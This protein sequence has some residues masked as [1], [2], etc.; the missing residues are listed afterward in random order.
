MKTT[1]ISQVGQ[2][3]ASQIGADAQTQQTGLGKKGR[4]DTVDQFGTA[5]DGGFTQQYPCNPKPV[6][7]KPTP[8]RPKTVT[9]PFAGSASSGTPD[10]FRLM[11]PPGSKVHANIAGTSQNGGGTWGLVISDG[12]SQ[13]VF[14]N[15]QSNCSFTVPDGLWTVFFTS[16]TDDIGH[17]HGEISWDPP[18][19]DKVRGMNVTMRSGEVAGDKE[20]PQ[21]METWKGRLSGRMAAVWGV[22][23][24]RDDYLG[25]QAYLTHEWPNEALDT[26]TAKK[27]VAWL[28]GGAENIPHAD[29]P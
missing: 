24:R 1:K 23:D 22:K 6:S 18:P 21:D 19:K 16:V 5:Q 17:Y 28:W 7:P 12:T 15:G 14:C 27:L 8:E 10:T 13:Q 20:E 9:L 11:I 2:P 29:A 4:L 25:I 26:V 3:Q